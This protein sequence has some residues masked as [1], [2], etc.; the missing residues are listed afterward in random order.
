MIST[1]RGFLI[2][3]VLLFS[4]FQSFSVLGGWNGHCA[5]DRCVSIVVG[6]EDCP[7]STCDVYDNLDGSSPDPEP[8]FSYEFSCE[9]KGI[10]CKSYE[11][12][13]PAGLI[14]NLMDEVPECILD[15]VASPPPPGGGCYFVVGEKDDGPT[16]EDEC[17]YRSAVPG[18]KWGNGPQPNKFLGPMTPLAE[19]E[20]VDDPQFLSNWAYID[21]PW[22]Y[23]CSDNSYWEKCING[24]HVGNKIV[25]AGITYECAYNEKTSAYIWSS[26]Q[27][28]D[29]YTT[30]EDCDD[31]AS[32]DYPG[33]ECPTLEG[34]E[35]ETIENIRL[36]A[37]VPCER[38]PGK[39]SSCAICINN[40][41]AEV[42][43]DGIN[44]D[45]GG[46]E[47]NEKPSNPEGI[48][49]D[50]C[51][52]NQASCEQGLVG[53]C[54]ESNKICSKQLPCEI[55]GEECRT[56]EEAEQATGICQLNGPPPV[57]TCTKDADCGNLG[58]WE[59]NTESEPGSCLYIATQLCVD[60]NSCGD[61]YICDKAAFRALNIY[62]TE[63]SWKEN[64]D[65]QGYCCG[66]KGTAD[67]GEI[68]K[69]IDSLDSYICLNKDLVSMEKGFA[70]EGG[71]AIGLDGMF[72][73]SNCLGG[74]C[75][76]NAAGANNQFKVITIKQPGEIAF[77]VVSNRD[78]WLICGPQE[79]KTFEG[80]GFDGSDDLDE[81]SNRFYCYEEGNRW[82]WAECAEDWDKRENPSVK[83]RY[84]GESLYTLPL[85]TLGPLEEPPEQ[86]ET[87][88]QNPQGNFIREDLIGNHIPVTYDK[89]YMNYY[90][91]GF[92]DFSGYDYLNFMVRFVDEEGNS[93][94]L[95][96]LDLP[97]EINIAINGPEVNDKKIIYFQGNAL[98]YVINAPILNSS[99]FMHVQIPIKN[100]DYQA[101][102]GIE[103]KTNGNNLIQLR[104]IY[105]SRENQ[106]NQLCSGQ[107]GLNSNAWIENADAGNPDLGITGEN[108][109]KKL[110]GDQAW[111][112]EDQQVSELE[113]AANCCGNANREYYAGLSRGVV[114]SE[115]SSETV[116][117]GCWNSQPLASGDTIMD[118]EFQVESQ[119]NESVVSYNGIP[120][121]IINLEYR[122]YDPKKIADLTDDLI[123]ESKTAGALKCNQG[124]TNILEVGDTSTSLCEFT[125]SEDF[126]PILPPEYR[127]ITKLWFKD[128]L[129]ADPNSPIELF[130]YDQVTNEKIG[131]EAPSATDPDD[132]EFEITEATQF[133]SKRKTLEIW[134]HP[135]S[136]IAKLKKNWFFPINGPVT[137]PEP[138]SQKD[139][140]ACRETECLFP[141][142]GNP[143]YKVTNL[144]P[145]LYELYYVTGNL[146]AHEKPVTD[147]PFNEY[148]NLRVKR[149]AQQVLFYNE[150]DEST[151]DIAFYGCRAA[152]F[153]TQIDP[154]NN[155]Q[156]C[157]VIGD[158]FC[159]YSEVHEE[160]NNKDAF[161]VVNSWSDEALTHVGYADLPKP[162]EGQN[163][164]AYY[165]TIELT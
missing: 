153:I 120:L 94:K 122:V 106:F 21:E 127:G 16:N 93:K 85:S 12:G 51:H 108:L 119:E 1:K 48:T 6:V 138:I 25:A 3:I 129:N 36:L 38:N 53:H 160:E 71:D 161:T 64:Q 20:Q 97:L 107:K 7:G 91:P 55:E 151:K 163:I 150:G 66:F 47:Q 59:C 17:G 83:G 92:L 90:G 80:P 152:D 57:P 77:D 99:S 62:N 101:I 148:A 137:T 112:G 70:K 130:F 10:Q 11:A 110:Y 67:L 40:G 86:P 100:K 98:G 109:C 5:G 141:L 79:E 8:L 13:H 117:Y 19:D 30:G 68:V 41:A 165:E 102:R 69:D 23:I 126:S 157:A 56:S 39:Y 111:L 104:N 35:G 37:K 18:M 42:C 58:E 26:D 156:Y 113:P 22:E 103:L 14:I 31:D 4:L 52:E 63:F 33:L 89:L 143:P 76:V 60:D 49:P 123:K 125:I 28:G 61:G 145:D 154:K 87:T 142:P 147:Q 88:E 162:E 27:D 133:L 96:N 74:W 149:I 115:E 32:D 43:G 140:Y 159:S 135:I 121:P 46:P 78:D 50:S 24:D 105:L 164:S 95:E 15:A 116:Y 75:W 45:C 34:T 82:S 9:S 128:T 72:A 84:A 54:S 124:S 114:N 131:R 2:V 132:P 155:L 73:N 134:H 144:N 136:V 81:K 146:A 158:K 118:V 65:G 139:T 29:G 44:N